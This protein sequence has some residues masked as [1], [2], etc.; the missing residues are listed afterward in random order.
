MEMGGAGTER[1]Q[2]ELSQ[3]K[4]ENVMYTERIHPVGSCTR[5]EIPD[6]TWM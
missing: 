3:M 5:T 1:H 4:N 2:K 6:F